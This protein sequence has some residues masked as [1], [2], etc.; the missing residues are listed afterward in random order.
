M[1]T[2]RELVLAAMFLRVFQ[3]TKYLSRA[4]R[5]NIYILKQK[6]GSG[7]KRKSDDDGETLES[8]TRQKKFY[9]NLFV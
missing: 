4:A 6:T 8:E 5:Y 3:P 9:M 1:F 7:K 2:S